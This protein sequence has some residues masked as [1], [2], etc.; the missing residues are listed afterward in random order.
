MKGF[1]SS[2]G[3]YPAGEDGIV[4]IVPSENALDPS[5][6]T[7]AVVEHNETNAGTGRSLSEASSGKWIPGGTVGTAQDWN[8]HAAG[9]PDRPGNEFAISASH[10]DGT[11]LGVFAGSSLW[12]RPETAEGPQPP[13]DVKAGA[14]PF[15][16]GKN[17]CR[18]SPGLLPAW[19]LLRLRPS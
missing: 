11:H 3:P 16:G 13:Q 10:E 17:P 1:R 12:N 5:A 19:R 4:E 6:G 15:P 2:R 7:D 18:S 14:K 8:Q 9:G